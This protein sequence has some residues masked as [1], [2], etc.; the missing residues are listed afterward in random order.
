VAQLQSLYEKNLPAIYCGALG[1][2]TCKVSNQFRLSYNWFWS[3]ESKYRTAKSVNLE[4]GLQLTRSR[5]NFDSR[6]LCV[7]RP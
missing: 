7:R 6:A 5:A 1:A 3:S 4:D 2:L